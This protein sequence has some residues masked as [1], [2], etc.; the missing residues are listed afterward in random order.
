MRHTG[1]GKKRRILTAGGICLVLC[2][3]IFPTLRMGETKKYPKETKAPVEI[4]LVYAYQNARWNQGIQTIAEEFNRTHEGIVV[5]TRVQYASRV[6][7]DIL[8]KLQARGEMGDIIQ[9]KTPGLYAPE[10]LLFPIPEELCGLVDETY[11]YGGDTF[12]LL[13]VGHTNGILYNRSIFERCGVEKPKN[14]DYFLSVCERLRECGVTPVGVAGANLWH[15]EFW[16]NHFFRNDVLKS[17][18]NWLAD[19]GEGKVSWQDEEP[20]RMLTHLKELLSGGYVN[21]DWPVRKDGDLTYSMSEGEPAMIYTGSWNALEVQKLNPDL[22][23]GW[24]FVPDEE[25]DVIVSENKDVYWCITAECG[26]DEDRCRAACEFLAYFY[27]DSVYTGLCE[28]ILAFPVTVNKDVEI[29]EGI[30][31]EMIEGFSPENVHMSFYIGDENTPQGFETALLAE[32][33]A[34]GKGEVTVQKAAKRLDELW[35]RFEEQER[36]P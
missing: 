8:L 28:S 17:N 32:I 27:S 36:Q 2:C 21:E 1:S 11:V 33:V 30:R 23:L 24:F 19:C 25:G 13:A 35:R 22:R 16:V 20:V 15:L 3:L 31:Q 18:E 4:T 6:Y 14:W 10:G 12:G 9:I 26:N 5:H 7:E 29:E 34:L